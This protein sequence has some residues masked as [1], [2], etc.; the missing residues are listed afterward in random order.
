MPAHS[1]PLFAGLT[2]PSMVWGVS[3]DACIFNGMLTSVVFIGTGSIWG[4][5]LCVPVHAVA[6]LI[7]LKDPRAFR[8]LTLW[9]QTK[10]RSV[11][12]VYWKA[13]T[14]TPLPNTR[15]KKRKM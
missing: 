12:R 5:L 13:S 2:R 11:S 10:G 1:D 4:L 6:F 9:M 15:N 14:A 8:F 3:Y 7:C